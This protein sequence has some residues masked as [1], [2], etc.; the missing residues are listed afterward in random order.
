[1]IS[2]FP[3]KR[4]QEPYSLKE[5]ERTPPLGIRSLNYANSNHA[6]AS[7]CADCMWQHKDAGGFTYYLIIL[8]NYFFISRLVF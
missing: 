5:K 3:L 1:M 6:T 4:L 2:K 7:Q 8:L